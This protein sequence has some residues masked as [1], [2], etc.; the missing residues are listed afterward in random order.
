MPEA[1][2]GDVESGRR[3]GQRRPGTSRTVHVRRRARRWLR[4]PPPYEAA[5]RAIL[6]GGTACRC[7]HSGVVSVTLVARNA[8][9]FEKFCGC[10]APKLSRAR[11]SSSAACVSCEAGADP[12]AA[13]PPGLDDGDGKAAARA[14][15]HR[16][17]PPSAYRGADDDRAKEI[18]NSARRIQPVGRGERIVTSVRGFGVAAFSRRGAQQLL[19]HPLASSAL[20]GS[21]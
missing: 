12:V 21:A 9:L 17:C 11:M 15:P 19:A 18:P 14:L 16:G 2:I 3:I 20:D 5:I 7:E 1:P 6:T 10:R 13:S 4:A 8:E